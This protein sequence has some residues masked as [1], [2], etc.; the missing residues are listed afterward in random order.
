MDMKLGKANPMYQEWNLFCSFE[1]RSYPPL[2]W[3]SDRK[4]GDVFRNK[5][6]GTKRMSGRPWRKRVK[7]REK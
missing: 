7:L 3:S 5:I 2:M 6:E 1:K 4:S